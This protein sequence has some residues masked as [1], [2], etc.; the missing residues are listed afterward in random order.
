MFSFFKSAHQK[1]VESDLACQTRRSN[2]TLETL[3]RKKQQ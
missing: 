3:Y 1:Q 2:W